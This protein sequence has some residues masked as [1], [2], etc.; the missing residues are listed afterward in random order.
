MIRRHAVWFRALLIA[1]DALLAVV[2]LVVLSFWRFGPDWAIWWRE[3]VPLPGGL[4]VIYAG[5]WVAVL[6]AERPVP[7][8][9]PLVDPQRGD[10][11]S[12]ARPS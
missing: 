7:T 11:R 12:S 4:L 10:R 2:L 9:S 3:I 8:A 6:T 5:G 1:A